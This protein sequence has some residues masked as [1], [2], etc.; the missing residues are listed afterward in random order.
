[1]AP[2][3][4]PVYAQERQMEQWSGLLSLILPY[5]PDL[6][7]SDFHLFVPLKDALLGC[8]FVDDDDPQHN[9]CEEL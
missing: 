2:I 7:T 6:P 9:M 3:Y 5:S 4:T 8:C 1:M